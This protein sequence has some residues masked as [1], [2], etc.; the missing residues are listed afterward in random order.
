MLRWA[1]YTALKERELLSGIQTISSCSTATGLSLVLNQDIR[2]ADSTYTKMLLLRAELTGQ[3]QE[4]GCLGQGRHL[5][6]DMYQL[7]KIADEAHNGETDCDC[8]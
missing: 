3:R 7:D 6:R 8:F 4:D 1:I 5:H 2:K